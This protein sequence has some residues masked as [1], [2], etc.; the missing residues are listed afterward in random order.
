V[1][2]TDYSMNVNIE[3]VSVTVFNDVVFASEFFIVV[4]VR[5]RMTVLF[6]SVKSCV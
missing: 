6:C 2:G 4:S 1:H 3:A 5:N